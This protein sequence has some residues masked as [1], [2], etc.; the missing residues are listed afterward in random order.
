MCEPPTFTLQDMFE[1]LRC[2]RSSY[3]IEADFEA[4]SNEIFTIDGLVP[5]GQASLYF[6][7]EAYTA[8]G[9]TMERRRQTSDERGDSDASRSFDAVFV[10]FEPDKNRPVAAAGTALQEEQN[11]LV[12]LTGHNQL[13]PIAER[14]QAKHRA[15]TIASSSPVGVM[16]GPLTAASSSISSSSSNKPRG[17]LSASRSLSPTN[18]GARWGPTH[19]Q[20]E[21]EYVPML[22][23]AGRAA[24]VGFHAQ[25][26][27]ALRHLTW[28]PG[29]LILVADNI[30]SACSTLWEACVSGGL[31]RGT[32]KMSTDGSRGRQTTLEDKKTSSS[33]VVDRML[34]LARQTA[35]AI[36]HCHGRGVSA[37]A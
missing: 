6:P 24:M 35:A 2:C 15:D 11:T 20:R 36:S 9:T 30:P 34:E 12:T 5:P 19:I 18:A 28:S 17:S 16:A 33:V 37:G 29:E 21:E 8:T 4:D 22:K 23:A 27:G 26:A 10:R 7:G 13:A 25:L 3:R 31:Y 32:G 14:Q 1:P